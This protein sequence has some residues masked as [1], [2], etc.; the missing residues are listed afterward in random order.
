MKVA[1]F[2]DTHENFHNFRLALEQMLKSGVE[3]AIF[4]GDYINPGMAKEIFESL[5]NNNIK[6]TAIF[7]NN[8]GDRVRITIYALENK[9]NHSAY[10]FMETEIDGKKVFLT[11]YPEIGRA[12]DRTKYEAVFYGHD[13]KLFVDQ[14]N[15]DIAI[16]ANPGEI[17]S[18]VTGT[19][20]FLVWDTSVK[21]VET[22][23]LEKEDIY[24]PKN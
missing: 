5:K 14:D 10:D 1:V 13:H 15:K 16:L 22:I 6:L 21:S 24:N 17:S 12:V 11:H 2:S 20:S 7:G 3:E 18:H 19:V 9:V 23:F 4:L 8:D